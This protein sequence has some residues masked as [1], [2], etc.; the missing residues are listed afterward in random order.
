MHTKYFKPNNFTGNCFSSFGKELHQPYTNSPGKRKFLITLQGQYYYNTSISVPLQGKKNHKPA[1]LLGGAGGVVT[2][3]VGLP[4]MWYERSVDL[5]PS[6]GY[7]GCVKFIKH[8][9]I[10]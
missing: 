9:L 3:A 6:S 5:E 1:C 4:R 7:H 8:L 2:L 10:I